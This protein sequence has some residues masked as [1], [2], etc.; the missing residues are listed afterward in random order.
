[1]TKSLSSRA[2]FYDLT[3]YLVPGVITLGL[4]WLY[5]FFLFDFNTAWSFLKFLQ[6]MGVFCTTAAIVILG[7]AVGHV[8]NSISSLLFERLL[9]KSGF[10]K[11]KAWSSRMSESRKARVKEVISEEFK[12]DLPDIK[13]FDIRIRMENYMPN[14]AITG[15]CFLSYY[16][17]CRTLSLVSILCLPLA[18]ILCF[19]YDG[20]CLFLPLVPCFVSLC[21]GYQY[22]RFVIYYYDFLGSTL[23]LSVKGMTEPK[24]SD[25]ISFKAP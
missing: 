6:K 16:G 14:A 19:V 4:V 23:M 2:T 24:K 13:A 7:Y 5:W 20:L 10:D 22:S 9:F 15:L 8:M 17:M 11:W 1:M 18:S 25:A 21:F 3:G 12:T